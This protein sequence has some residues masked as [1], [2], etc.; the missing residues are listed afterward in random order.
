[1]PQTLC[2][3]KASNLLDLPERTRKEAV[4]SI[5]SVTGA[6]LDSVNRS[7]IQ[8]YQNQKRLEEEAKGLQQQTSRFVKYVD[9][10]ACPSM[11]SYTN[12]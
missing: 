4:S 5:E 9:A 1:M 3:A 2:R 7:V 8:V 12:V 10:P 11:A 6:L